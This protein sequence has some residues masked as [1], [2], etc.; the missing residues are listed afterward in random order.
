[1]K[2]LSSPLM[3]I[4]NNPEILK[5][6]L[7]EWNKHSHRGR[8]VVVE[9]L[10]PVAHEFD[11][12]AHLKDQT[13]F[14]L[15]TFGPGDRFKGVMAHIRKE[16]AEI[17]AEPSDAEEWADAFLLLCD[18]V[19]RQGIAPEVFVAAIVGKLAKNKLR[20]WPDWRMSDPDGHIEHV[21]D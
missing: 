12:V 7:E 6:F 16:L 13:A 21:R 20:T 17:E 10:Q 9:D 2:S 18:G 1:M 5:L 19:M 4:G 14:S 11:F 15:E 8:L 3:P